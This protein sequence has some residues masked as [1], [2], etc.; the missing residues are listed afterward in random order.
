MYISLYSI[1]PHICGVSCCYLNLNTYE[2]NIEYDSCKLYENNSSY[3]ALPYINS[4]SYRNLKND[5]LKIYFPRKSK[6]FIA[7]NDDEFEDY[8]HIMI[9]DNLLTDDWYK[10]EDNF[11]L[12]LLQ[13]WCERNNI[14][15][16]LKPEK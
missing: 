7:M 13:E 2:V 16:T 6:S 3:I 15:Y 11:K 14:S 12:K 10:Y 1:V 5:F 9:N 4:V 8:F